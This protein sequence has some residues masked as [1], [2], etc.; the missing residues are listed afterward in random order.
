[1]ETVLET[2]YSEFNRLLILLLMESGSAIGNSKT[3][4]LLLSLK[5]FILWLDFRTFCYE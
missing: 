1:M 5:V 4:F 2:Q 3:H